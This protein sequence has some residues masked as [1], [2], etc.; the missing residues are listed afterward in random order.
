MEVL[1]LV[2]RG[3]ANKNI[4]ARLAITEETVKSHIT[5]SFRNSGRTTERMRSRSD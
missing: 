1:G 2:A 5:K 3:N 4:A